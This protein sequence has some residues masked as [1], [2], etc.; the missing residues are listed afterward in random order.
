MQEINGK[1]VADEFIDKLE[2]KKFTVSRSQN[3]GEDY[4]I[5]K[6]QRDTELLQEILDV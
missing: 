5:L 6:Q 2:A 3:S 1:A 4:S